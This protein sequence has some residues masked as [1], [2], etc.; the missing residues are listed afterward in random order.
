MA[1]DGSYIRKPSAFR[2]VIEKGGKYEPEKGRYHLYV[3]YACPWAHR[4]LITRII[5]G[6]EE[7]I[8]VTV[9]SPRMGN[10]GWPF[11]KA[12]AFPGAGDDPVMGAEH[13]KDIYLAV[14]PDHDGKFTVPLLFDKKTKMAVNNE[15]SEILRIFNTAFNHLISRE[16]AEIDLYPKE[17]RGEIEA[18]HEWIYPNIN[19]GVYRSGFAI[20]QGAYETAVKGLFDSLDRVEKMFE[21]QKK[22]DTEEYFLIGPKLTESDI[23]LYT[24]IVRFDPVYHGHFKCNCRTIRDGYPLIH[25]WMQNL[26]WNHPAFKDTTDFDH[27]KTHYYW[28]HPHINPTRVIPL[29]P[30]PNIRPL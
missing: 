12:D 10:H 23:R 18:S 1:E 8:D 9:V 5:K 29:G 4:T 27:I 6:L 20:T 19:N 30:I 16:K 13:I 7:Y 11:A 17:L 2:D 21:S 14:R 24:T 25:R 3:S 26:Y 15:S 28:S 22:S